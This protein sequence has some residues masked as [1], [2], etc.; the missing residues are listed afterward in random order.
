MKYI[1]IFLLLL[2]ACSPIPDAEDAIKGIDLENATITKEGDTTTIQA[3]VDGHNTTITYDKSNI[4]DELLLALTSDSYV[5]ATINGEPYDATLVL[6]ASAFHSQ[7]GQ[8][9]ENFEIQGQ[10]GNAG[11]IFIKL[12]HDVTTKTYTLGDEFFEMRYAESFE[13]RYT[14]TDATA[15]ITNLDPLEGTFTFETDEHTAT[16]E[17]RYTK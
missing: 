5:R 15:T 9:L 11:G 2:V 8:M 17:F 12:P 16:G 1:I 14:V 6:R 7:N 4:E 13:Q 10:N 3:Q